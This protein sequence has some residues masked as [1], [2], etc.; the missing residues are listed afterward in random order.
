MKTNL[1][2]QIKD[3]M[4]ILNPISENRYQYEQ[5]EETFNL[6]YLD[7]DKEQRI[8]GDKLTADQM[9]AVLSVLNEK[10]DC[11]IP[12]TYQGTYSCNMKYFMNSGLRLRSMLCNLIVDNRTIV[13]KSQIQVTLRPDKYVSIRPFIKELRWSNKQDGLV[14][15]DVENEEEFSIDCLSDSECAAIL[16]QLVYQR[17][18]KF[19]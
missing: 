1:K 3:L 6:Y 13:F 19:K 7:A 11:D 16:Q 2:K 12:Y 9:V 8:I 17:L 15:V 5:N 10:H 18:V 14:V 4:G